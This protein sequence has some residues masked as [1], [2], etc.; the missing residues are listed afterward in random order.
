MQRI[1]IDCA[2]GDWE[3]ILKNAV[4]GGKDA[5]LVN[6][7][8]KTDGQLCEALV[9]SHAMRFVL[10]PKARAGFLKKGSN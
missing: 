1:R 8:Y 6:F 9:I 7:N 5:E 2:R 3:N 10:D 4:E